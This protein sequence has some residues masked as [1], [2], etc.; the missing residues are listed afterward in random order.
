MN[1]SVV[2]EAEAVAIVVRTAAGVEGTVA[3]VIE[4][5]LGCWTNSVPLAVVELLDRATVEEAGGT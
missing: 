1:V 5:D 3:N 2:G 4:V